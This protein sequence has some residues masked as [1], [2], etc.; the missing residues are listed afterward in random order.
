MGANIMVNSGEHIMIG[1]D[2]AMCQLILSD[3]MV[4]RKHCLVS[5]NAATEQ[6]HI[7][8]YSKNGIYLSDNRKILEGQSAE[9]A[10]G[11]R[12]TLADGRE[13]L[14]LE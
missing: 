1:R 6:Y 11:T 5:F 10:R 12:L 13:V 14:E 4:S 2:P 7:E 9:A 3:A 8:C